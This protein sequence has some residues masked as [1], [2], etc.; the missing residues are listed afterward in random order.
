[1]HYTPIALIKEADVALHRGAQYLTLTAKAFIDPQDDDSHTNLSWNHERQRLEGRWFKTTGNEFRLTLSPSEYELIWEDRSRTPVERKQLADAQASDVRSWWELTAET[2]G[3]KSVSNIGLHYE[4][5][6]VDAYNSNTLPNPTTDM[7]IAWMRWRTRAERLLYGTKNIL[8]STE[9]IRVWPHHF[10]S[11]L[12]GEVT[13]ELAIG[14]GVAPADGMVDEPYIYLYGWE[15]NQYKP[16]AKSHNDMGKWIAPESEGGWSGF[17]LPF[18][19]IEDASDE[20]VTEVIN[21]ATQAILS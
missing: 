16:M 11:G 1:M 3:E 18:T 9:E 10:D 13:S 4:L 6:D 7:L 8:K 17:V 5:P 19:D 15:D 2:I 14:A 12:Y 20:E 21:A